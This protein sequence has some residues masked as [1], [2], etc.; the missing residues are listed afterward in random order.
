MKL[1]TALTKLGF[2]KLSEDHLVGSKFRKYAYTEADIRAYLEQTEEWWPGTMDG[3][4]T[5]DEQQTLFVETIDGKFKRRFDYG[6]YDI[7]S[8]LT[9]LLEVSDED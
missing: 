3:P 4:A 6:L 7:E 8:L 5:C 2:K 1:D 9:E